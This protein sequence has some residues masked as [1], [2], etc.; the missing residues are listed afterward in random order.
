MGRVNLL[1]WLLLGV[2]ASRERAMS[3]GRGVN[4]TL[5]AVFYQMIQL[6][7]RV[8]EI[9]ATRTIHLSPCRTYPCD[10]PSHHW[11][12]ECQPYDS[13][14][15][16]FLPSGAAVSDGGSIF[17]MVRFPCLLKRFLLALSFVFRITRSDGHWAEEFVSEF[18][19]Y[20]ICPQ[21]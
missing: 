21:P 20:S 14:L 6:S 11:T 5:V 17:S 12:A 2:V 19:T 18:L 8:E 1:H 13:E 16:Y 3:T 7:P 15:R 4:R 10:R 9:N